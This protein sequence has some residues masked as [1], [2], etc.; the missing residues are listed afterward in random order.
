MVVE[1]KIMVSHKA[2]FVS[3]FSLKCVFQQN[4]KF[5]LESNVTLIIYSL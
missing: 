5:W 3:F 2:R 4:N 1:M